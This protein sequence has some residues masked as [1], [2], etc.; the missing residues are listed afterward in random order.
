MLLKYQAIQSDNTKSWECLGLFLKY[1]GHS[2]RKIKL[3]GI[4]SVEFGTHLRFTG[5]R[6]LQYWRSLSRP[7]GTPD[8]TNKTSKFGNSC[9]SCTRV[10]RFS[11]AMH[12][13]TDPNFQSGGFVVGEKYF[14]IIKNFRL[15][16]FILE[17][18]R[19]Q[20]WGLKTPKELHDRPSHAYH[21]QLQY[22]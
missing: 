19:S 18:E 15:V 21:S 7:R 5:L 16:E 12:L 14:E 13:R 22:F 2:R 4:N 3:V 11:T 9:N 17:E 10:I 1:C 20:V 8:P 6:K